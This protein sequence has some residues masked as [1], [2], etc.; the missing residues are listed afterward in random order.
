[1]TSGPTPTFVFAHINAK[2]KPIDRGDR[3]EDPLDAALKEAGVG[4]VTGG[5]CGLASKDSN[6][7][8]FDGIDIELTDLGRGLALVVQTLENLGAPKGSKLEFDRNGTNEELAFGKVEGLAIYLNGTDLPASTYAESDVNVV[9][10]RMNELLAGNG[11]MLDFWEGPRETALYLYGRS[12][13]EMSDLL[14]GFIKHEPLCEK[15]RLV[16]FA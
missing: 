8:V 9:I 10:Q 12:A 5:G 13:D 1:M 11:A 6:E 14:A 3:F 16:R 4:E 2:A 7:I 15:A